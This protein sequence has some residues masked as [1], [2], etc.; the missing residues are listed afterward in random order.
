MKSIFHIH[1]QRNRSFSKNPLYNQTNINSDPK[2]KLKLQINDKGE[3]SME[4][5]IRGKLYFPLP[6]KNNVFIQSNLGKKLAVRICQGQGY[7]NG[8][9]INSHSSELETPAF[10]LNPEEEN[11]KFCVEVFY[12]LIDGQIFSPEEITKIKDQ[13]INKLD[14]GHSLVRIECT[15][16]MTAVSSM[17]AQNA[18]GN[19]DFCPISSGVIM[20]PGRAMLAL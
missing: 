5:G 8:K 4:D 14:K 20:C 17:T 9:L 18:C 1:S 2:M 12:K 16:G 15:K 3:D 10:T 19:G 13:C 11:K 6:D 7:V